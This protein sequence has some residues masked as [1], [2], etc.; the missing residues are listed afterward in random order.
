M[1]GPAPATPTGPPSEL[2]KLRRRVEALSRK[3]DEAESRLQALL[4][5][6]LPL[7]DLLADTRRRTGALY[8]ARS[9][10][11]AT[12]AALALSEQIDA[13]H[14]M[15]R[16]EFARHDVRPMDAVGRT[17]DP[18][19]MRVVGTQAHP[20]AP[21]GTVLRERVTGFR[22]GASTLRVAQV[23]VAVP[24]PAPG[25]EAVPAAEDSPDPAASE[26]P[27]G[28]GRRAQP[29][30]TTRSQRKLPRKSSAG[31]RRRSRRT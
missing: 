25:S 1:N 31:R 11:E 29:R 14:L 4:S 2:D 24:G 20:S 13:A 17:V 26:V 8:G 7:D 23:V 21:A 12:S 22:L 3:R 19:E 15:L 28:G 30:R 6:L 5:S 27:P 9:A 18:A 16:S 10:R